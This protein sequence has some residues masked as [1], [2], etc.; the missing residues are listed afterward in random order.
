MSLMEFLQELL[1][2]AGM[3]EHFLA[4]PHGVLTE[5]GLAHLSPADVHDALVLVED[6]RTADFGYGTGADPTPFAPP[7]GDNTDAVQYLSGYLAGD[8]VIEEPTDQDFDLDLDLDADLPPVTADHDDTVS[9]GAGDTT[10]HAVDVAFG[11][12]APSG[13]TGT[14]EDP[15]ELDDNILGGYG[16]GDEGT[17][18][19]ADLYDAPYDDTAG[20]TAGEPTGDPTG[21]HH[22][23]DS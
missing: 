1:S 5:Q 10:G 2:D 13:S 16:E 12:A 23:I 18:V 7:P 22:D 15:F 21:P 14:Y 11:S 9:F 6:T 3:R 4:D 17:G 20:D 19:E 8:Q